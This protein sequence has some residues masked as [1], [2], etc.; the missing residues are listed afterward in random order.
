MEIDLN[1]IDR[2]LAQVHVDEVKRKARS[3]SQDST[4]EGNLFGLYAD[5]VFYF[6][7]LIFSHHVTFQRRCC[8]C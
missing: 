6:S 1:E 3:L 8:N 2:T 7:V 4:V 5:K